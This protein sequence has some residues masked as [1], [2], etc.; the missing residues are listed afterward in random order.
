L[1]PK[2]WHLKT[3]GILSRIIGEVDHYS[4]AIAAQQILSLD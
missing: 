1:R 3:G 2:L 4:R